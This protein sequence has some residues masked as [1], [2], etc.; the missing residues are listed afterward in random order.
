[1][2]RLGKDAVIRALFNQLISNFHLNQRFIKTKEGIIIRVY[3]FITE[4]ILKW[5]WRKFFSEMRIILL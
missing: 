5:T 3:I 1:M 2:I 4:K